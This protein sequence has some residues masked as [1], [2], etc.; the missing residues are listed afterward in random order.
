MVVRQELFLTALVATACNSEVNVLGPSPVGAGGSSSAVTVASVSSGGEQCAVASEG[1]TVTVVPKEAQCKLTQVDYAVLSRAEPI[2]EKNGVR[3]VMSVCVASPGSCPCDIEVSGVG[4]DLASSLTKLQKTQY[5]IT[6]EARGIW[7]APPAKCL[8]CVDC[9]C[10][11]EMPVFAASDDALDDGPCGRTLCV[12]RGVDT[13][14]FSHES[15]GMTCEG[16]QFELVASSYDVT[17]DAWGG[18]ERKL[19]G[20]VAA[21]EGTSEFLSKDGL[22]VRAVRANTRRDCHA[23]GKRANG[24]W[25]A[26]MKVLGDLQ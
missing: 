18:K 4:V 2:A 5:E 25:V 13:C 17:T 10:P 7:M 12:R 23:M 14:T 21:K 1:I 19:R 11:M 16:K 15:A 26:V 6:A 8:A 3:L 9:P 24:A 20:Q 22:L